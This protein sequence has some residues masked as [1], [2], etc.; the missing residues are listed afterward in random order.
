M[1]VFNPN[2]TVFA[3]T[4]SHRVAQFA[5]PHSLWLNDADSDQ[6]G[7]VEDESNEVETIDQ[8]E[9]FGE[10]STTLD[11]MVMLTYGMQSSSGRS[12][13]RNT[14]ACLS[15]SSQLYLRLRSPSTQSFQIELRSSSLLPYHTA[16]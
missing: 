6:E 10:F 14:G 15:S 7:E 12:L 1:E 16:V 8:D 5:K 11:S 13:T 2:P 3:P 9:I 4:K